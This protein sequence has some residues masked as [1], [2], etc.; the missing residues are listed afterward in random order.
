MP[1]REKSRFSVKNL[2][3]HSTIKFRRGV[4]LFHKVSGVEK[5]YG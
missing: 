3:S 4:L 2:L 1:M 5:V